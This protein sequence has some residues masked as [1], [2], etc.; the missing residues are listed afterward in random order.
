MMHLLSGTWML[1]AGLETFGMLVYAHMS[2]CK[3]C[4]HVPD[5]LLTS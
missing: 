5:V 4:R 2:T 3:V 1:G